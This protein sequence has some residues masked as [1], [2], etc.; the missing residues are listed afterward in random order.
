MDLTHLGKKVIDEKLPDITEFARVYQGIEPITQPVP[1]QPTAHYAMGGIPTNVEARV[2]ID[3]QNSVLPGLYAAGECAC[4][5]VHGANRL[6]TNSLLDILVFGRRAG[7]A[8]TEDVR[9]ANGELPDL[10]VAAAE[11][12]RGEL[13]AIRSRPRGENAQHIRLELA[14]AMMD[15]CGVFRTRATL[16]DMTRRLR[17][18]RARYANVGITDSGRIFN[19]ELLEAREVGY[20][21]DC[22]EA[23]VAAAL[24]REESRGG[25][26]REDFPERNDADWLKHSLAYRA[27]GGPDLRYKPVTITKFQPKPRTY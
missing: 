10:P 9:A 24:A 1:I 18:L 22:A 15:D 26:F 3:E 4:V 8:M 2:V 6:G 23:T 16:E 20:L 7:R 25:H 11:P 14:D 13:E 12:V 27:E 17:D 19:T 5:S 21:L